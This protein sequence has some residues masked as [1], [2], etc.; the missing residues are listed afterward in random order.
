MNRVLI[1]VRGLEDQQAAQQVLSAL[2]RV[3][4]V[5]SANPADRSQIEVTYDTSKLTVMDLIRVVRE[6]GYLAG[7][8]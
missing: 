6:Q 5:Q 8:L 1:G 7:M 2:R 4:G 3:D